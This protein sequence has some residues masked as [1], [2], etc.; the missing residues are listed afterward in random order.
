M[1]RHIYKYQQILYFLALQPLKNYK[2]H[3]VT[4][5]PTLFLITSLKKH[6]FLLHFDPTSTTFEIQKE[7]LVHK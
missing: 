1:N 7:R 4:V 2:Y 6:Y 5:V 3:I